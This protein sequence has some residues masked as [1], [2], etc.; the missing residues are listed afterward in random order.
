MKPKLKEVIKRLPECNYNVSEAGRRVGYSESYANTLLHKTIRKYINCNEDEVKA[1]FILGLDKDIKRF[2]REK[3]NTSY[4]RA[5]ELKSRILALPIDKSE[6]KNVNPDKI[7]IAYG[8][9]KN[10]SPDIP[11]DVVDK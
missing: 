2:K 11:Q 10:N 8:T 9:Q 4:M 7:V 3:D 5:K 6:V 1:E